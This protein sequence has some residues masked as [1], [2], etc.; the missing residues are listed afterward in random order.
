VLSPEESKALEAKAIR[1]VSSAEQAEQV[2][3]LILNQ[4]FGG[5]AAVEESNAL[6]YF[7]PATGGAKAIVG[8][9]VDFVLQ[10]VRVLNATGQVAL[11]VDETPPIVQEFSIAGKDDTGKPT[12]RP[13]V[14][15]MVRVIDKMTGLSKWAVKEEARVSRRG[16][17]LPHAATVAIEK[18]T[19]KAFE[20]HPSYG[21]PTVTKHIKAILRRAGIDPNSVQL[22]GGSPWSDFFDRAAKAG[23][24]RAALREGAKKKTGGK[25]LS[26]TTTPGEAL[27]AAAAV[28]ALIPTTAAVAG[29]ELRARAVEIARNAGI[30]RDVLER[31]W[32][33]VGPIA[34]TAG[35]D[36]DYA[37]L[38]LALSMM[39]AGEPEAESVAGALSVR[40]R[41]GDG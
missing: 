29:S 21:R 22:A 2:E 6:L 8:P 15:A 26:A 39:V 37:R 20:S 13:F 5:A 30:P 11:T 32:G 9:T 36:A 24:P 35:G 19:R 17:E 28:D 40:P 4:R 3:D 41:D 23:V 16:A 38:H 18:A 31:V 12:T 25:G 1:V 10:I 14:R 27:Q 7:I 33:A 34:G